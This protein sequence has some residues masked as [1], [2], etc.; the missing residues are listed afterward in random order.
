MF[1]SDDIGEVRRVDSHLARYRLRSDG[2]CW[3]GRITREDIDHIRETS[4]PDHINIGDHAGLESIVHG[5]KYP[6]HPELSCEY[7]RREG[8]LDRSHESIKGEFS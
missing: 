8:S 2:S 7:R 4:D 3:D 5:N 6:F 1:L